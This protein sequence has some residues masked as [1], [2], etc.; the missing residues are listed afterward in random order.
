MVL[1]ECMEPPAP[2]DYAATGVKR[3]P[4]WARRS[5]K[6]FQE[7]ARRNGDLDSAGNAASQLPF[8]IVQGATFA[9]LRRES[10]RQLLDLDFPGYSVG[11]LA[12]CEGQGMTFGMTAEDTGLLPKD[13]PRH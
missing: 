8:G 6:H 4:E 9:D 2:R 11:C 7:C 5:R 1:D 3:T 12:V 10:A 13:P